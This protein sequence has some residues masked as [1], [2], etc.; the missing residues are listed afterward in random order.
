M[1]TAEGTTKASG[2]EYPYTVQQFET[3]DEAI[4]AIDG[5]EDGVLDIINGQ[6]D[7][8]AKQGPKDS[9]REAIDAAEQEG[10]DEDE[11]QQAVNAGHGETEALQD[12]VDAVQSAQE[13]TADFIIGRPRRT[14]GLTK[15][16]ARE[17]GEKAR[18]KLG[19][20][21]LKELAGELGIDL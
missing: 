20:D 10:H 11:I 12:V 18:E 19:D 13:S 1:E 7:Q 8:S 9:V 3:L 2:I 21:E 17:F 16:A 15:T 14:D 4:E 6:Q 5:G